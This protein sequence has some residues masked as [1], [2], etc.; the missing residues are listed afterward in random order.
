MSANTAA[1]KSAKKLVHHPGNEL[2]R[3]YEHLGRIEILEGALA[4]SPF[5]DVTALTNLAQQQLEAGNTGNAAALL[6]AAEH[7]CFAA[8]APNRNYATQSPMKADLKRTIT[9]EF[10]DL[11]QRAEEHWEGEEEETNRRGI[12]ELFARALDQARDAFTLGLFRPALEFAR[13]AE[14]LSHIRGSLP[15]TVA[16]RGLVGQLAS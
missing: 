5:V 12:E 8:L 9:I 7:L 3:A 10:E 1:N 6:E 11:M 14:V 15:A 16:D 4:G 13:A 2:R